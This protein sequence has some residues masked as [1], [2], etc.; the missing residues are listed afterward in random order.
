MMTA[1]ATQPALSNLSL[2]TQATR[3]LLHWSLFKMISCS[4]QCHPVFNLSQCRHTK[5]LKK[6]ASAHFS[7]NLRGAYPANITS[8]SAQPREKSQRVRHLP[9]RPSELLEAVFPRLHPAIR[10]AQERLQ[11]ASPIHGL[12][13]ISSF[14]SSTD[15]STLHS[16]QESCNELCG[17]LTVPE[18]AATLTSQAREFTIWEGDPLQLL[19]WSLRGCMFSKRLNDMSQAGRR[20]YDDQI[21]IDI[22]S[23]VSPDFRS[24]YI[25]NIAVATATKGDRDSKA[26]R[27]NLLADSRKQLFFVSKSLLMH[28]EDDP[29]ATILK[30]RI[31]DSDPGSARNLALVQDWLDSCVNQE[32]SHLKFSPPEYSRRWTPSRVIRV[33]P[34]E[35]KPRL[36]SLP[37]RSRY[38]ALTYCWGG[39]QP[40]Q[41]VEK[42]YLDYRAG[43]PYEELP[44]TIR[45]A[46]QLTRQL[47]IPYL[48][49]DSLCIIQDRPE[50]KLKELAN[51]AGFLL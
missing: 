7:R 38:V 21:R 29:A 13:A 42:N 32:G 31:C 1:A 19:D 27:V 44:P 50:D 28:V 34:L 41:T 10:L 37:T 48:W 2:T 18:V 47:G 33:L 45:D 26:L 24:S 49:V 51:M 40:H 15:F 20:T 35:R 4:K 46:I 3:A 43:I 23:E 9:V 30:G 11:A 39:A 6:R 12:I 17:I 36:T 5:D 8:G 22:W 14:E 25:W 16:R